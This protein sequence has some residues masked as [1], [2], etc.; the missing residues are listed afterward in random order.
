MMNVYHKRY[1]WDEAS[2]LDILPTKDNLALI[3]QE[4]EEALELARSLAENFHPEDLGVA[5]WMCGD[6]KEMLYL[7][8]MYVEGFY[9]SAK[10]YFGSGYWMEC[11]DGLEVLKKDLDS[12]RQ[13]CIRLRSVWDHSHYPFYVYWMMD[14]G[15][16]ECLAADIEKKTGGSLWAG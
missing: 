2:R 16:L 4:K 13:F 5:D 6:L 8:P 1:Q 12:L 11:A 14:V 9:L 7:F 15:E 10:V 3:Y